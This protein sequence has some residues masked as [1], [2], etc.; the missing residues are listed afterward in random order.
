MRRIPGNY[1]YFGKLSIIVS[2]LCIIHCLATPVILLLLPAIATFFSETIEQVIVLSV[3]PL[4]LA[5][6][7]PTWL[8]HKNYKLLAIYLLSIILI[9][10]SQ[11]VLHIPHELSYDGTASRHSWIKTGVTFT[12]VL[13]LAG[14]IYKNNR[15]THYCTH[16]HH[17][18]DKARPRPD[19]KPEN[20]SITE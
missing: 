10:F 14:T 15:H 18:Q 12:G 7:L 4:S 20:I 17:H 2:S 3:L 13:L 9:L 5:G 16:P 8:R 6:F 19:A 1:N 11:F